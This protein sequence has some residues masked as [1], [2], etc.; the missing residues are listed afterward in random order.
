[1]PLTLK[2]RASNKTIDAPAGAYAAIVAEDERD[3]SDGMTD[4]FAT[5]TERRVL[6]GWRYTPRESFRAL[7]KAAAL[8]QPTRHLGPGCDAYTVRPVLTV[9]AVDHGQHYYKDGRAPW[10]DDRVRSFDTRA[11]VDAFLATADPLPIMLLGGVDVPLAWHVECSSIEHRENYSMG[12][13]NYLKRGSR[14]SSAMKVRS[15]SWETT[16]DAVA[17]HLVRRPLRTFRNARRSP[18]GHRTEPTS[19][20]PWPFSRMDRH[21]AGTLRRRAPGGDRVQCR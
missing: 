20:G 4:Y 9:D 2:F 14:Y 10:F 18:Q 8:Y 16:I 13:G 12:A 15:V 1:M 21:P 17:L 3:E 5:S 11:E 6:I 19:R 7:R